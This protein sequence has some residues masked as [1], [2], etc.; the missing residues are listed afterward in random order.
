MK[1]HALHTLLSEAAPVFRYV[2]HIAPKS[3]LPDIKLRGLVAVSQSPDSAWSHIKYKKP[4]IFV[5]T[6]KTKN[7][8]N[9]I[10]AM[11]S[12]K[13]GSSEDH[14]A[15]GDEEWGK[16]T[17]SYVMLTI[18]LSKC[19]DVDLTQDPNADSWNHSKILS[20]SVPPESIINVEPVNFDWT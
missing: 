4:S 7:V 16:F 18:D 5:F 3:T 9:E 2:Y 15:W 20:G 1:L 12:N 8:I 6:R 11:L 19:S 10:L 17:N 13:H 14:E